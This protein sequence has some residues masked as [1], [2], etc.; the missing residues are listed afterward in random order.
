[1]RSPS[2]ACE[3]FVTTFA[4]T[5]SYFFALPSCNFAVSTFLYS[6]VRHHA[7]NHSRNQK[8]S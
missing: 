3:A 4:G 7:T 5:C 1:M 8:R 6:P 2:I